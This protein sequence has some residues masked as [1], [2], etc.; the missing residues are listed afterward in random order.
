MPITGGY[1]LEEFAQLPLDKETNSNILMQDLFNPDQLGYLHT[2]QNSTDEELTEFNRDWLPVRGVT[3]EEEMENLLDSKR[4][5]LRPPL[6]NPILPPKIT[7][8][9]KWQTYI[10]KN[11]AKDPNFIP[12]T[13]PEKIGSIIELEQL[14]FDRDKYWFV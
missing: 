2:Y 6:E 8:N 12:T 4:Q 5:T 10:A 14:W 7:E 3:F 9:E 1:T 11:V 13:D